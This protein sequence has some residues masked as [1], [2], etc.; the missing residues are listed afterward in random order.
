[1]SVLNWIGEHPVLTVILLIII[2]AIVTDWIHGED[3]EK[4]TPETPSAPPDDALLDKYADIATDWADGATQIDFHNFHGAD[5]W[6]DVF[7]NIR[8]AMKLLLEE[9]RNGRR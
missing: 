8:K 1:M 5:A 4:W 2:G 6:Q 3:C 9:D 7:V